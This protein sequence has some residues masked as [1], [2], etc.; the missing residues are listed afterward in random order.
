MDAH[1]GALLIHLEI[2]RTY[3][4][5]LNAPEFGG[6]L[7]LGRHALSHCQTTRRALER[8]TVEHGCG[9]VMFADCVPCPDG[10]QCAPPNSVE[11]AGGGDARST[12]SRAKMDA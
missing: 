7:R 1:T 11:G 12:A 3:R 6:V 4:L 8:H 5:F 10:I 9:P 2:V